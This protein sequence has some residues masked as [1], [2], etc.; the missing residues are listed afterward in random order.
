[1]GFLI[2]ILSRAH[3]KG[4]GGGGGLNDLKFGAFIGRFLSDGMASI[5]VTGL[6]FY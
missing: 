6:K 1:M 3:V 2:E 4:G 5:A